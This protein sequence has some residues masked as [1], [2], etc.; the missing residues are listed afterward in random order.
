MRSIEKG[1]SLETLY[2]GRS[3]FPYCYLSGNH[4]KQRA[5]GP[6]QFAEFSL[7]WERRQERPR[8][9][10]GAEE[11]HCVG[12]QTNFGFRHSTETKPFTAGRF[13]H[14]FGRTRATRLVNELGIDSRLGDVGNWSNFG[15]KK[16]TGPSNNLHPI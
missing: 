16:G 11:S 12:R 6:E 5:T 10:R 7:N 4:T 3:C 9:L 8:R 15:C 13:E 1:G 14:A 2:E